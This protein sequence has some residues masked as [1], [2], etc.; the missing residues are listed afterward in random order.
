MRSK[1]KERK[2]E[3]DKEIKDNAKEGR[4]GV[5]W[6]NMKDKE[7]FDEELTVFVVEVA[8]KDHMREEVITAKEKEIEN[9]EN[10]GTFEEVED[11][12]QKKICS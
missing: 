2:K 12:G 5:Y 9:L 11:T 3:E 4:I 7:Y 6:M 10:Y 8:Q 1:S